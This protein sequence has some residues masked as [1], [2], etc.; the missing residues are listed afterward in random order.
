LIEELRR[1]GTNVHFNLAKTSLKAQLEIANKI[2]ATHTVIIG[3]KEVQDGTAIVRDMESG[4]QEI[5]DQ[6]KLSHELKKLSRMGII[7]E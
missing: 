2:G 7:S 6:K 4:I 1:D 3:Q 5:V